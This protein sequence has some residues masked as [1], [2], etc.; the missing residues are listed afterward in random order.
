MLPKFKLEYAAELK[1]PL[2]A[3]G[4]KMA[5]ADKAEPQRIAL[6]VA[7]VDQMQLELRL[8]PG[9]YRIDP[10][11]RQMQIGQIAKGQI[12]V[13]QRAGGDQEGW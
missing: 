9:E 4:M 8:F 5:F 12:Y 11:R 7:T 1:Q 3:L 2:R 10:A 6:V 13:D